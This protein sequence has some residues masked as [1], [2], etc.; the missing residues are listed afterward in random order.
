MFQILYTGN[1]DGGNSLC[2]YVNDAWPWADSSCTN[3][4]HYICENLSSM[5]PVLT[6]V[7]W[8]I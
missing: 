3:Q 6:G 5:Y 1:P 2:G 7:H 8:N 4:K